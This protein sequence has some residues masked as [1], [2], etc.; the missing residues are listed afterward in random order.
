[1]HTFFFFFTMFFTI[2]NPNLNAKQL[3]KGWSK[4]EMVVWEAFADLTW[5]D[6]PPSSLKKTL[7]FYWHCVHLTL[8]EHLCYV[9]R[10]FQIRLLA[11]LP[12]QMHFPSLLISRSHILDPDRWLR[13]RVTKLR[14]KG[15][16]HKHT[17]TCHQAE[18]QTTAA[19][20]TQDRQEKT[21]LHFIQQQCLH[22]D[23]L[24]GVRY[25]SLSSDFK[26]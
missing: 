26:W 19:A 25:P 14:Y 21:W 16:G 3:W 15:R 9:F 23:F 22:S 17:C 2:P 6:P 7:T 5:N 8:T 1:M 20:A 12:L 4:A 13:W 18:W 10:L 11:A 24:P